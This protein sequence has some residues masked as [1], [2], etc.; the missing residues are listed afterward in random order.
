[1]KTESPKK[2]SEKNESYK[3]AAHKKAFE[4]KESYKKASRD[5]NLFLILLLIKQICKLTLVTSD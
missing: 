5:N 1:M 2:E 3:K 4:K